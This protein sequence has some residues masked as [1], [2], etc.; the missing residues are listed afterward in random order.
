MSQ[1]SLKYEICF[2]KYLVII[3][4]VTEKKIMHVHYYNI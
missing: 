3:E 4:N 2:V 1:K